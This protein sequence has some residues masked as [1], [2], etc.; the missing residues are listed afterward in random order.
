M[1]SNNIYYV[2]AYLRNKD[3]KTAKA[4]TPYY[5]GKGKDFRYKAR[6]GR[7]PVPSDD[8]YL[9]FVESNLTE[10][11]ALAI[12]RRLIK[13]YGRKN[14]NTGILLNRT[15]GG[16][17]ACNVANK[18]AHNKGKPMSEAAK[19]HLSKINTGKQHTQKTKD[20]IS[21]LQKGRDGKPHTDCTKEKIKNKRALQIIS[22]SVETREK[23]RLAQSGKVK[24]IEHRENLSKSKL[25]IPWSVNR[26]RSSITKGIPTG[27][28]PTITC[29]HCGKTGGNNN[30]TRW[31]FTNCKFKK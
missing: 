16:D 24:S 19:K 29:P 2:Y 12:E 22:H 3:S 6:H 27:P 7:T 5:I 28:R 14:N 31:H 21:K 23:M 1:S 10:I 25:G 17:G 8:N 13:W 9:I 20:K 4:G 26:S 18:K 15:D 30:M 11:G